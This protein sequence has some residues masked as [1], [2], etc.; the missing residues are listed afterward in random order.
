MAISEQE[1]QLRPLSE[2]DESYINRL[3]TD[4]FEWLDFKASPWLVT[5]GGSC[6][7]E[8]SKYVSAFA[9]RSGGYLVIGVS[10]PRKT[11]AVLI[12]GGVS[13]AL[14]DG[15]I[16]AWLED[17]L[18]NLV[19]EPLDRIEVRGVRATGDGSAI[20]AGC[21]VLVIHVPASRRA[22]HQSTRT[23]RYH[24]RI[25]SKLHALNHR[26]VMDIATQRSV[27]EIQITLQVTLTQN[28]WYLSAQATN[29]SHV[30]ARF[31]QVVVEMPPLLRRRLIVEPLGIVERADGIL[32]FRH[33]FSNDANT[34]LF[35]RDRRDW[36]QKLEVAGAEGMPAEWT[37]LRVLHHIEYRA[38]A[39]NMPMI[40]AH[41]NV[42]EIV[43]IAS[44]D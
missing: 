21:C 22:P 4:E 42:A 31:V 30:V 18:P 33:R 41:L 17:K 26:I 11:G 34:P 19:E 37:G 44:D 13:I 8:L 28:D 10:D 24:G 38:F 29:V 35:P 39:D 40:T 16:D 7:E 27:P 43:T 25:G 14:A 9:N 2:W 23:R 12:D 36:V 20:R 15:G 1:P 32:C 3:P 5:Q 6:L